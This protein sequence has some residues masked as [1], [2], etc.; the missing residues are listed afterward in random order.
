[1]I[2]G[3]A[4]V[5]NVD[6]GA[7]SIGYA[8]QLLWKV[9]HSI[10]RLQSEGTSPHSFTLLVS[11]PWIIIVAASGLSDSWTVYSLEIST[12]LKDRERQGVE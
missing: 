11:Q 9:D 3:L 1:M 2:A 8:E 5:G 12:L 10:D 4:V 7:K 6:I